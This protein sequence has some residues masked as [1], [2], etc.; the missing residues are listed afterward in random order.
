M[1]DCMVGDAPICIGIVNLMKRQRH[2]EI[3]TAIYDQT[4]NLY[5]A[6]AFPLGEWAEDSYQVDQ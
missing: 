5:S 6:P 3:S 1:K 4:R 2:I